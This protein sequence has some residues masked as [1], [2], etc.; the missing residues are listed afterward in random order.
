MGSADPP[1]PAEAGPLPTRDELTKAWGDEILGKLKGRPR[2]RFTVGRWLAVDDGQAV[3][4]VPNEPH[5]RHAEEFRPDV[6][7]VVSAHFHAKVPIRLVVD[8][9]GQQDRG[10]PGPGPARG[11]RDS[12]PGAPE[13]DS[14]LY[15]AHTLAEAPAGANTPEER[16]QEAFPGA[17]W[18]VQE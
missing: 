1:D 16:L 9:D 18:E 11:G 3:F 5:L 17:S 2:A 7:A 13:D 10:E 8:P 6:E 4:A 15:D 12:P 14:E